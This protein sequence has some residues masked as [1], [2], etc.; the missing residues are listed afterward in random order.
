MKVLIVS[1]NYKTIIKNIQ[2]IPDEYII[3]DLTKKLLIFIKEDQQI[4]KLKF[5]NLPPTF[6]QKNKQFI[7]ISLKFKNNY[8]ILTP[9]STFENQP[10]SENFCFSEDFSFKK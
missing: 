9:I 7:D 6:S 5:K 10:H 1:E 2:S 4:E 8:F 3:L